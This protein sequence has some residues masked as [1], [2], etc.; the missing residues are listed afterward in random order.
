MNA[1]G[2]TRSEASELAELTRRAGLGAH[3]DVVPGPLLRATRGHL[4]THVSRN[5]LSSATEHRHRAPADE[6]RVQQRGLLRNVAVGEK[7]LR[8]H[9]R[10][11]VAVSRR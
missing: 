1:A 4:L 7:S 8:K 10:H 3:V 9:W 2:G 5:E 11:W 6:L